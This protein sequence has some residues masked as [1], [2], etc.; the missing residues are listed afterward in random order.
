VLYQEAKMIVIGGYRL[1]KDSQVEIVQDGI[2]V[3]NPMTGGVTMKL[4]SD[5]WHHRYGH[6]ATVVADCAFIFGGVLGL[7]PTARYSSEMIVLDLETLEWKQI[8]ALGTKPQ[9]RYAHTATLIGRKIFVFGGLSHTAYLGDLWCFDLDTFEW[10]Q[11]H[12]RSKAEGASWPKPRA[13]HGAV[14]HETELW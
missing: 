5:T 3:F 10:R 11:I 12:P 6:S 14:G 8:A 13:G 9:A 2:C 4:V 7:E 1:A